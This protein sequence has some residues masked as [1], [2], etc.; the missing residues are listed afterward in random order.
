MTRPIHGGN[1]NWAAQ[2][3]GC[4]P[5]VILDFS[6]SINPLGP[7]ESAISAIQRGLS[8]LKHYPD[9]NY[10]QLRATIGAWHDLAPDWILAGN[11]AAELLTW[12]G[13]EL[14]EL[15]TVYVLK[16]GFRDYKR[17]LEAFGAKITSCPLDVAGM[18][19]NP[20]QKQSLGLDLP[21][22]QNCGL[23]LNNP[24]N[25]TG[26]LFSRAEILPY[27][28][29][30]A[31]VVIDEAF[32]DFL[33]PQDQESL[34]ADVV[35]YPN[36]VVLRSLTKFYSLPGLRIGYAVA[37]PQRLQQWQNW[38]DPWSVNSLAEDAA[39]AVIEDTAFQ[40]KTWTWLETARSR[41]A[42]DL[43]R[44]PHLSPLPT[45]ANFF[46]VATKIPASQL[47]AQLLK[48]SQILIRDCLSFPELGEDYFRIAIRHPE[49]NRK[50]YQAL[51][52]VTSD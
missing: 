3:A 44:I 43:K 51:F 37:H 45:A 5:S 28:D 15:D 7:P 29:Q 17:A 26:Q 14:A 4:S 8:R 16:P 40:E 50:L 41:F 6:A 21:A 33:R 18:L 9:P 47:Q 10:S 31:L 35:N 32:M 42:Q 30:F 25:P 24:H 20:T 34:I 49:E 1:L 13:R 48:Q 38:R 46:L 19:E 12:V 27:L 22:S 52:A 2:L 23:L 39:L 36:L 11:G